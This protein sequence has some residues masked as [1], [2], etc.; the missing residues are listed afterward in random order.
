MQVATADR[1]HLCPKSAFVLFI[2]ALFV[3]PRSIFIAGPYRTQY[4]V[5]AIL[6]KQVLSV[7]RMEV[8]AGLAHC[9][10]V[11][12][13]MVLELTVLTNSTVMIF[14]TLCCYLNWHLKHIFT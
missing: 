8:F 10:Y 3:I 9:F 13:R 2:L 1:L 4:A 14:Q 7:S 12:V 11:D 5:T 6:K